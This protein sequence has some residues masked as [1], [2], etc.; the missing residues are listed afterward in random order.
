MEDVQSFIDNDLYYE[1]VLPLPTCPSRYG[2]RSVIEAND[3]QA[4]PNNQFDLVDAFY[5]QPQVEYIV[6]LAPLVLL[7]SSRPRGE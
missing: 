1:A 2:C 3:Q 6:A 4:N 7:I 5:I